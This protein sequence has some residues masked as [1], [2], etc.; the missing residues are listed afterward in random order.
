MRLLRHLKII[1]TNIQADSCHLP[2]RRGFKFDKAISI[3]VLWHIPTVE[4]RQR[5]LNEIYNYLKDGGSFIVS[6]GHD[7]LIHQMFRF[8]KKLPRERIIKEGG[9]PGYLY[10]F[11]YTEFK[12]L[13]RQYFIIDKIDSCQ[14]HSYIFL[15]LNEQVAHLIESIIDLFPYS[16]MLC[17]TLII[18]GRK[19]QL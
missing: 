3:Q 17:K 13:I 15:G 6:V 12:E 5:A 18:S 14:T 8:I 4:E 11:K 7:N 19:R 2:F 9:G 10:F 16:Y 1:F